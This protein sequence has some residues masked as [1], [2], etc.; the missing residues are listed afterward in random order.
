[1]TIPSK[2]ILRLIYYMMIS[3]LSGYIE[4]MNRCSTDYSSSVEQGAYLAIDFG[5]QDDSWAQETTQQL[6]Q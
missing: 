5:I 1:M 3:Y 4:P 2:P 6:Q